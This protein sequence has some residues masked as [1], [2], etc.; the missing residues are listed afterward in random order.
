MFWAFKEKPAAEKEG[1]K[2][3]RK[4]LSIIVI[5]FGLS[6]CCSCSAIKEGVAILRTPKKFIDIGNHVQLESKN[7]EQFGKDLEDVL[8]SLMDSV[9]KKEQHK[10]IDPPNI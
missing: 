4:Y 9:E 5:A 10:F 2:M 1:R 6:F 8:P 7:D 3:S